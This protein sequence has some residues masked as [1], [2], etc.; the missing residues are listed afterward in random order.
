MPLMGT[1]RAAVFGDVDGDGGVDV[2]VV[3]RDGAAHLL[4][5]IA[6]GRGNWVA[7]RVLDRHG[8]DA[9]GATVRVTLGERVVT[10]DVR[11]AYSYCASNDPKIHIGLGTA[12]RID[13]VEIRWIDGTTERFGTI[14]AGA[15][16]TLQR[17]RGD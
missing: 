10:R 6:P 15:T 2:L 12:T 4:R 14:E 5:N 16:T 7:L 11:A 3:N 9:L 13:G 1:S 8:R 17:G